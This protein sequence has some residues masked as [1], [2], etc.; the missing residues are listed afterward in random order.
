MYSFAIKK[1][2]FFI[3]FFDKNIC[4]LLSLRE[5]FSL[6]TIFYHIRIPEVIVLLYIAGIFIY[7]TC[8][9]HL[10]ISIYF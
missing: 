2:F 9:L 1:N 3:D 8:C 5:T 4:F 10:S 7:I 6:K